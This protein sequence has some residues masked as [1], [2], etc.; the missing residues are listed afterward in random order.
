MTNLTQASH[1]LFCR[2]ADER[3]E[4]LA[5][6]ATHCRGQ[7][8]RSSRLKEPSATFCPEVYDGR[9]ALRIDGHPPCSLNDWSFSQLCGIAGASKDTVNRLLPETAAQVLT[10]TLQER[11]QDDMDLQALVYNDTLVRAVNGDRYRRLWN[12]ELVQTLQEFAVDFAPPQKGYNGA[13][14]LYAGEQDM[15]CFLI[16]P[17][18]WTDIGGESFAPGFFVWNSEVGRRTV[19]ISTFW[20]QAVCANHIVWDATEVTEITRRHTGRVRDTLA[21]IRQAIEQ[22][23]AKR[24]QR[25][26]R[27]AKVVAKAM[28]TA[29][30]DDPQEAQQLL[31]GATFT[32]SLATRAV[33]IA[34]TSGRLTVWTMVNAL[35]QL[36]RESKFAGNRAEIDQKA[37]SLLDLATV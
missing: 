30:G 3:F 24:D 34:R 37:S 10:E 5:A 7:K 23:A 29:Y 17:A 14:G 16:D 18:G 21:I 9:V 27:F 6:L 26:D 15:F 19:G 8:D 25:K 33:E 11:S 2:P 36:A 12:I 22:L 4:T 1:E 28:E 31:A 35:T 32:R 13:T 20:F